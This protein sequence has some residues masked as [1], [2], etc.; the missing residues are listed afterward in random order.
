[1]SFVTGV[2]ALAAGGAESLT[3]AVEETAAME[4]AAAAIADGVAMPDATVVPFSGF[5]AF[6][7]LFLGG[8]TASAAEQMVAAD[9][10]KLAADAP[11][12]A[13]A[14]EDTMPDRVAFPSTRALA[15]DA[16]FLEGGT[17]AAAE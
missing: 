4:V 14:D 16:P 17:A 6:D 12:A 10:G 5:L 3:L 7:A 11:T 9:S 1:M 8:G 13:L 2:T 15:L